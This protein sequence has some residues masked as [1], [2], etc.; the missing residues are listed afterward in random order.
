VSSLVGLLPFAF[1]VFA[2]SALFAEFGTG[3]FVVWANLL[4]SGLFLVAFFF[5]SLSGA[6]ASL[7]AAATR[8]RG[9]GD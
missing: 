8:D 9:Y 2:F 3:D 4:A 1:E 5:I 6:R 7:A